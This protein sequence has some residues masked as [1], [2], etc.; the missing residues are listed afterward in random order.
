MKKKTGKPS[1][2]KKEVDELGELLGDGEAQEQFSLNEK[3][4]AKFNE[5][6]DRQELA[7]ARKMMEDED[8]GNS[9]DESS[10]D[11]KAELL[12]GKLESKIFQTL[13]KIK[14][15]DPSIYDS[16]KVFFGDDDF[17]EEE[18]TKPKNKTKRVNYKDFLRDTLLKEGADAIANE[19]D[20]IEKGMKKAQKTP[21]EEQR[22]MRQ[23]IIDASKEFDDEGDDLFA[24]RK[25]TAAE[26]KDEDAEFAS[27][28]GREA[29]RGQDGEEI[30]THYW[31]ADE[32]LDDSEKFLRDYIVNK[33]WMETGSIQKPDRGGK[34]DLPSDE[35]EEHLDD[36]D[37]YEKDYNFR[38]EVEEGKQIQGHARFPEASVRERNDKRKRQRQEKASRQETEK[39]RR[40][41]ELKRLKNLKRNEIKR[42]L[43]QIRE[44][45]GND[46]SALGK[47]LLDEDFNPEAHDT[48]M[49]K[50]LGDDYDEK[51]ETLAEQELVQ[52][53]EGCEEL[54]V[55]SDAS[56]ALKKTWGIGAGKADGEEGNDDENQWE[57]WEGE[58]EE[59]GEDDDVDNVEE[60]DDGEDQ[61][62]EEEDNPDLWF[63]CDVCQKGIPAGKRRFDCSVCENYT[64]CMACF[65]IR[66]HPHKF[67]RKK[68]PATAMPPEN[69]EA[70][71]VQPGEGRDEEFD[72]LFQLDYEDIIGGDLPVRFKY[73][74]VAPKDFGVSVDDILK[75]TDR[76]L[77]QMVSLK[78]LRTYRD[79]EYGEIESWS[80]SF[81]GGG[82]GKAGGK[83]GGGRGKAGGGFTSKGKGKGKSKEN[84]GKGKGSGKGSSK[85]K[86]GSGS[87]DGPSKVSTSRLGAY[88]LQADKFASNSG[89][90]HHTKKKHKAKG[91]PETG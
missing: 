20:A 29:A 42:R 75:K 26:M 67:V 88:N 78:K 40:V 45:T 6:K 46:E 62:D 69:W 2:D 54:D 49:S 66:R 86:K 39:I 8:I 81:A 19:E 10:E 70:P 64:L 24:I 4:A 43:E 35:E 25:K 90:G 7:R 50:M 87:R 44:V 82:R 9:S 3:F 56:K 16:K 80:N 1:K 28:G 47:G 83:A 77:N 41:E 32:D 52:A 63:M 61:V 21:A 23:S 76:Q 37:Q 91:A 72:E 71:K 73:R 22:E 85:G 38:F 65:R 15:K 36:V 59:W 12:T 14:S 89:G 53:P 79:T 13:A 18:D 34:A 58:E 30:M 60:V 5:K 48:E 11:E 55:S 68:V 31:K 57:G 27:F 33:E 74:K 84:G 51:D 17:K